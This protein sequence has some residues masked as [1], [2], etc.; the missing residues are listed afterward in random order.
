MFATAYEAKTQTCASIDPWLILNSL[1]FPVSVK[2]KEKRYAWLNAEAAFALGL[3]DPRE[4][5]GRRDSDFRDDHSAQA[6]EAETRVLQTG[7]LVAQE[8]GVQVPPGAAR[9]LLASRFPVRDP[10]GF[11]LAVACLAQDVTTTRKDLDRYR[12][13]VEGAEHGLWQR[14][15]GTGEVWY[16][17]RWKGLLG[18]QDH[19]LPN[20][21]DEWFRRVHPDDLPRVD[22]EMERHLRGETPIYQCE[23]RMFHRDGSVRWVRSFATASRDKDGRPIH[24]AGSHE[25][26]TNSKQREQFYLQVLDSFPGLVW[27]K[28]KDLKFEFVNQ[29]LA[30]AFGH[31]K[32]DILGKGDE[33]FNPDS[34]QV[35]RFQADDRTVLA[36][37]RPLHISEEV[38]TDHLGHEHILATKKVPLSP[39]SP[40]QG[41]TALVLGFATDITELHRARRDLERERQEL[42][43][44]R[45]KLRETLNSSRTFLTT[46]LRISS[47][48]TA[49]DATSNATKASPTDQEV[50][51]T[52]RAKSF[53]EPQI[54]NG[55]T[56][57]L[58]TNKIPLHNDKGEA[59]SVLGIYE[60]ITQQ[61]EDERIR[62]HKDVARS[63][64]HCLRNWMGVLSGTEL[65]LALRY[66]QLQDDPGFRRLRDATDFLH[67][68]SQVATQIATLEAAPQPERFS[69]R[70]AVA[71][72]LQTVDERRLHLV[73]G[74]EDD[75]HTQGP[76]VHF[77]NAV[78]ELVSNARQFAPSLDEGGHIEVW[79]EPAGDRVLLHVKNNGPPVP[80]A[81]KE[82]IFDY[83]T[84]GDPSRTGM[85]LGYV[86]W[87]CQSCRG[88]VRLADS[89]TG[90]HFVLELPVDRVRHE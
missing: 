28:N 37:Q 55:R 57:T 41:Q 86:R 19:E 90:A 5:L 77:R 2:D 31:P 63:I 34:S 65:S 81:L 47:S 56:R 52:N 24:L 53:R 46:S 13:A 20:S 60:D 75:P 42:I 78:L 27:V 1:P 25:D 7:E 23:Y 50:L 45:K 84:S 49:K 35:A 40:W 71:S 22:A 59:V 21:R 18:Y 80:D 43:E 29:G 32:Q 64:G 14:D 6:E 16:S 10:A 48:R 72:L 61:L 85:G 38:L 33:D 12:L 76:L 66:P 70:Q 51:T 44:A 17:P 89:E 26:I 67:Q 39:P 62:F 11:V 83:F 36:T 30:D 3:S 54:I 15:L 82:K 87:V 9:R 73:P 69:V 79:I 74:P 4:A 88:S 8:E 58:Q 68:A